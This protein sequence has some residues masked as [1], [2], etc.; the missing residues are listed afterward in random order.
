MAIEARSTGVYD[1]FNKL[2]ILSFRE[3]IKY[4]HDLAYW[5]EPPLVYEVLQNDYFHRKTSKLDWKRLYSNY[6]KYINQINH[7]Q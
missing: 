5:P 7:G 1:Q 6:R 4:S 2:H 3:S